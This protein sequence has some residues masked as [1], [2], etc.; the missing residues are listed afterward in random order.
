MVAATAGSSPAVLLKRRSYL[1]GD[2]GIEKMME[3]LK[4]FVVSIPGWEGILAIPCCGRGC[5]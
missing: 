4:N 2:T 3:F 1:V 5:G